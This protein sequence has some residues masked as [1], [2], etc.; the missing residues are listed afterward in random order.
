MTLKFKLNF[1]GSGEDLSTAFRRALLQHGLAGK[2]VAFSVDGQVGVSPSTGNMNST[3]TTLSGSAGHRVGLATGTTLQHTMQVDSETDKGSLS[4][5]FVS[6][7]VVALDL[8]FSEGETAFPNGGTVT[9]T[10][11]DFSVYA[12]LK[13]EFLLPAI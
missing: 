8:P 5:T 3:L 4:I 12:G 1:S 7:T 13:S 10:A 11:I 6:G 2:S 9:L